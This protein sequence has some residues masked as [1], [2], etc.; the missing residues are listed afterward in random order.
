ML[1]EPPGAIGLPSFWDDAGRPGLARAPRRRGA[2]AARATGSRELAVVLEELGRACAPGP[3]LP[4]VVGGRGHPDASG[5]MRMQGERCWPRWRAGERIAGIGLGQPLRLA[6]APHRGTG[7]TCPGCRRGDR[8][9][10]ARRR[11]LVVPGAPQRGRAAP[12]GQRRRH[13]PARHGRRR[14]RH[15]W[16]TTAADRPDRRSEVLDI[17]AVLA[18]GR[19]RRRHGVV[20]RDRGRLRVRARAVRPAHRAVP[21]GEAP[22]RRHAAA[23]SSRRGRWRG[24][25]PGPGAGTTI[26]Q[27]SSSPPRWPGRVVPG[28]LVARWPRTASRCSAA[29][30]T[31]GSTTPTSTSSGPSPYRRCSAIAI[32]GSSRVADLAADRSPPLADRRSRARGR[33]RSAP[34]FGRSSTATKSRPSSEWTAA[35]ADEGYLVPYWPAPWGRDASPVEQLVID[36]EFAAARLRRPHLQVGGVGPADDHRPRH[37]PSSRSAGCRP[38]LRGEIIWCQLFSEPG[39][40]SDLASLTTRAERDDERRR[41]A[42]HRPEGVDHDG[43]HR[44][45]GAAGRPHR[46]AGAE[47]RRHHGVRRRHDVARHRHP[48]ATRAHRHRVLQRGVLRPT[49]SCP[50]TA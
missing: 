14:R 19:S 7:D 29:S 12:G 11:R 49:C 31:R 22:L 23:T 33:R 48:T 13:S 2:T 32:G 47:A 15:R 20:H 35:M 5:P 16:P 8:P 28:R 36:E 44:A 40:G 27:R 45:V 17:L 50:T 30:A 42:R 21:G 25:R 34:R 10:A 24:T 43:A 46:P 3:F 9:A 41:L 4:T 37:R 6:S 39:A 18:V 1:D 26:R 38:T